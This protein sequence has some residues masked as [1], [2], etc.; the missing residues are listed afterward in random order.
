MLHVS[1]NFDLDEVYDNMTQD[2]LGL[3]ICV[4]IKYRY[5]QFVKKGTPL[6]LSLYRQT[7]NKAINK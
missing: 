4:I 3:A 1:A 5:T 6:L 2:V 7:Q